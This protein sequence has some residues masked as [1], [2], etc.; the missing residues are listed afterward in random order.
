[1]ENGQVGI[2]MADL[3]ALLDLYSASEKDRLWC[4]ELQKATK[5]RR[6]RPTLDT[7]TYSGPQ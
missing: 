7:V 2:D 6:G 1:M 4:R 3:N 5:V